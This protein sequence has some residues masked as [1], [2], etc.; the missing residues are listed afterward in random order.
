MTYSPYGQFGPVCDPAP[1]TA[2][3]AGPPGSI[4]NPTGAQ[5]EQIGIPTATIN[6]G[7]TPGV[8]SPLRPID[9]TYFGPICD[10]LFDDGDRVRGDAANRE[11]E[12]NEEPFNGP[13]IPFPDPGEGF[14]YPVPVLDDIICDYDYET[15]TYTNCRHKYKYWQGGEVT[16]GDPNCVGEDCFKYVDRLATKYERRFLAEPYQGPEFNEFYCLGYWPDE[17]FDNNVQELTETVTSAV[18]GLG[19]NESGERLTNS[20]TLYKTYYAGIGNFTSS[21]NSWMKEN[22]VSPS[23]YVSGRATYNWAMNV[24]VTATGTFDVEYALDDLGSMTFDGAEGEN[25]SVFN[26]TTGNFGSGPATTTI[27]FTTVGW[28]RFQFSLE[29]TPVSTSWLGNPTGMAVRIAAIGF[30]LVNYAQNNGNGPLYGKDAYAE[31]VWNQRKTTEMQLEVAHRTLF[32]GER[33]QREPLGSLD[34]PLYKTFTLENGAI[35]V[36]IGSRYDDGSDTAANQFDLGDAKVWIQSLNFIDKP[37]GWQGFKSYILELPTGLTAEGNA[38][39]S[40]LLAAGFGAWIQPLLDNGKL[41]FDDLPAAN[42]GGYNPV[43]YGTIMLNIY[44]TSSTTNAQK[45]VVANKTDPETFAVDHPAWSTWANQ[46]MVWV[47][48]K[49]CTLPDEQQE[50]V[51]NINFPVSGHYIFEVASDNITTISIDGEMI[52]DDNGVIRSFTDFANAPTV[53]QYPVTSG[54]RRMVVRCTNVDNGFSDW[55]R[56]P[57]GWGIRISSTGQQPPILAGGSAQAAFDSNGNIVVTGSGTCSITAELDWNDNPNTPG[58]ALGSIQYGTKTWT[59]TGTNGRQ[60]RTLT[61]TAPTTVNLNVTQGTGYGG[62]VVQNNNQELCFKNG[63]RTN[64]L[65]Y[66][67]NVRINRADGSTEFPVNLGFPDASNETQYFH[68]IVRAV[69]EEYTSGR[70]GRTGTYPG[71]GRPPD[72]VGLTSYVDAYINNGGSLTDNPVNST[73]FNTIKASIATN[74]TNNPLGNE[75]DL[76]D[77]ASVEFPT[78]DCNALF[79][80][81]QVAN[82]VQTTAGIPDLFQIYNKDDEYQTVSLGEFVEN[83]DGNAFGF[84]SDGDLIGPTDYTMQG[85]NG[86][87]LILN[88]TIQG[89]QD[90]SDFDSRLRINSVTS[91]GTGYE[92][93]DLLTIPGIP[94]NPA[95]IKL[96]SATETIDNSAG[97]IFNTRQGVGTYLYKEG[98]LVTANDPIPGVNSIVFTT[99]TLEVAHRPTGY[100]TSGCST[101]TDSTSTD[102]IQYVKIPD[103]NGCTLKHLGGNQATSGCGSFRVRVIVDGV[104]IINEYRSNWSTKDSSLDASINPNSNVTVIVSDGNQANAGDDT[105]TKFEIISKT[106]NQRV[107][108]ITCRFEPRT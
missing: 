2:V 104:D 22:A 81:T 26:A 97:E 48:D 89:V 78:P 93:G 94:Y 25:I 28:K 19:T 85:G 33:Q 10:P 70:F 47:N 83:E 87:G 4:N 17:N 67:P 90:G 45:Y 5:L 14:T 80:I 79:K 49:E 71:R 20:A 7:V 42:K 13:I 27:T 102:G 101:Y 88:I 54:T 75:G 100:S 9:P 15:Q 106:S 34:G 91:F 16:L 23:P 77:I 61:V 31:T 6:E 92:A 74:Y 108:L 63:V 38:S 52:L 98:Q 53:F 95:P 46:Y 40:Q 60:T 3:I 103:N 18:A 39:D 41:I 32:A 99:L 57:G 37:A 11:E 56:N 62:Y 43:T 76:A 68:P 107:Q 21:W 30:N 44:G 72:L 86:T 59:Q 29:N 58:L 24:Y 66:S 105:S 36:V 82:Q 55:Q 12:R 73:I 65:A 8:Y 35:E 84:S 51:Y 96:F 64:Y 50:I 1:T 69:A